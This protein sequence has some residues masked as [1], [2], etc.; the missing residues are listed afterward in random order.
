VDIATGI[1][2]DDPLTVGLGLLEFTQADIK[3][4]KTGVK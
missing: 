2:S 3:I 4:K 1:A